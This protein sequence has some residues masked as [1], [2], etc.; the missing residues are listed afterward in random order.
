MLQDAAPQELLKMISCKCTKCCNAPCSCRKAG[1]QCSVVCGSCQ[2][3]SC[4]NSE[5]IIEEPGDDEEIDFRIE[6][7]ISEENI[8]EMDFEPQ[9]EEQV[10]EEFTDEFID[11]PSTSK[12]SR[13]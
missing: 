1:L 9:P 10:E 4:S 3:K 6:D 2:G 5:T 13:R 11:Q 8:E 7:L 12:K